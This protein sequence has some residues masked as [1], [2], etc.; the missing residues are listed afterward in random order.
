MWKFASD[1]E[2]AP[3]RRRAVMVGIIAVCLSVVVWRLWAGRTD[4]TQV[5]VPQEYYFT[6]VE[7]DCAHAWQTDLANVSSFFGGGQPSSLYPI[8]C[9]KCERRSAFMNQRCPW[10]DK[11]YIPKHRLEGGMPSED[12]CPHCG[13]DTFAWSAELD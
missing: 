5:Q 4:L 3:G 2:S 1:D 9:T 10:C 7:A 13:K 12:I 6:C 8:H 11:P